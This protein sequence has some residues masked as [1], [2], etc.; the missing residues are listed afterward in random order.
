MAVK[1]MLLSHIA[2]QGAVYGLW[3]L[4]V[5]PFWSVGFNAAG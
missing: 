5:L 3:S 4:G 1:H 2:M